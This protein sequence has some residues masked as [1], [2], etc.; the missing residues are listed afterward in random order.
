M[1]DENYAF[2][3]Q[4]SA[5]H[6]STD[7][8][9]S[10]SRAT[11]TCTVCRCWIIVWCWSAA[12]T[13]TTCLSVWVK[14]KF[15]LA[16]QA[17]QSRPE[18]HVEVGCTLK[19]SAASS[20]LRSL[21]WFTQQLIPHIFIY[22]IYSACALATTHSPCL[23]IPQHNFHCGINV[24]FLDFDMVLLACCVYDVHRCCCAAT[25]ELHASVKIM[26]KRRNTKNL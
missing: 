4:Q 19:K 20:P 22:Q 15:S 13:T 24:D 21:W 3:S 6:R 26:S 10:S 14:C 8:L 12:A 16:L 9:T 2:A 23:G 11:S 25:L 17:E 18:T 5:S 1:R 7:E